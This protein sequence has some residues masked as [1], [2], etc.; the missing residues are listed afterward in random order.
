MSKDS[1][2]IYSQIFEIATPI[3]L[4]FWFLYSRR[5]NFQK[6]YFKEIVGLYGGFISNT[7]NKSEGNIRFDGGITMEIFDIDD[8]GYF[9]GQFTYTEQKVVMGNGP[10]SINLATASINFFTGRLFYHW[11]LAFYKKRNPLLWNTNRLYKGEMYTVM[12]LDFQ[13]NDENEVLESVYKITHHRESRVIEFIEN[14]VN[15]KT[16]PLPKSFALLKSYNHLLDPY[17]N[18]KSSLETY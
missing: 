10:A 12:R 7:V 13:T 9:R 8:N 11:N 18:V 2:E 16:N 17:K 3:V 5:N 1:L 15:K 6:E 4:F 14:R